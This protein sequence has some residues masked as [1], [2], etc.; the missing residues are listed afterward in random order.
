MTGDVVHQ[1]V[2]VRLDFFRVT[3]VAATNPITMVSQVIGLNSAS[4]RPAT[5]ALNPVAWLVATVVQMLLIASALRRIDF[6]LRFEIDWRDP[7]V[8]QVFT[9]MLP[10]TVSVTVTDVLA[11]LRK[12]T[13]LA[14]A[15]RRRPAS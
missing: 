1:D 13:P 11:A 7:R 8:R 3:H 5:I 6:R 12:V 15:A 4:S 2:E 9:L 10:V 14:M